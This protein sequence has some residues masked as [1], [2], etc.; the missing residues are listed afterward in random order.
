MKKN[1]RRKAS[2]RSSVE[3]RTAIHGVLV[4][5]V[6]SV[7]PQNAKAGPDACYSDGLFIH[8]TGDQRDGVYNEWDDILYIHNLT[9]YIIPAVG[10]TGIVHYREDITTQNTTI[11]DGS[12]GITTSSGSGIYAR[13]Y[14]QP[15]LDGRAGDVVVGTFGGEI[16]VAGGARYDGIFA[17][18]YGQESL[19]DFPVS[20]GNVVVENQS[21]V[22]NRSSSGNGIYAHSWATYSGTGGNV[23]VTSHATID[24][25]GQHPCGAAPS[26]RARPTC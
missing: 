12:G 4:A 19:L 16:T 24:T 10:N 18:S 25:I 1:V 21:D 20:G 23:R 9:Q 3:L 5:S 15:F 7:A 11:W 6:L 22:F 17:E 8:C 26:P 13:T 2:L 14:Y